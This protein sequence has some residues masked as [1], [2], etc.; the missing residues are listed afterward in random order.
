MGRVTW[1]G[2]PRFVLDEYG[3]EENW[4]GLFR[5]PYRLADGGLY[6]MHVVAPSGRRWWEPGDGRPAIPFGLQ[7]LEHEPA[8]RKYR[9]LAIC[10]GESDAL[11]MAAAPGGEGL[12]V[13]ALPGAS[14]WRPE[15]AVHTVGYETVYVLGDGDGPG[16]KLN[17][18]IRRDVLNACIV[19]L[20]DGDD[21][22]KVAQRDVAELVALLTTAEWE[23]DLLSTTALA[24]FEEALARAA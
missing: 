11:A 3:V 7:L 17:A 20:A 21:A 2:L 16:R 19:N 13:I 9:C 6:A 8:F 15:W 10:E 4:E 23:R 1:K 14:T 24:D 22:R 18:A 12:D 5:F